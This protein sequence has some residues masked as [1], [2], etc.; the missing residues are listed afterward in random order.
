MSKKAVGIILIVL[1]CLCIIGS[2]TFL[3]TGGILG[4][5][6]GA[7]GAGGELNVENGAT[8]ETVDGVVYDVYDGGTT[9]LYN[10]DGY[11]YIGSLSVENSTYPMGTT[12]EVQYDSSDPSSFAVP[13][14]FD[15][16]G[17]V[18]TVVGIAGVVGGI[19]GLIIGVVVLIIGIKLVKKAK[20]ETADT[21]V[22]PVMNA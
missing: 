11:D 14:L 22:P 16:F 12:V 6:F 9:I 7:I 21:T 13:E 3:G 10:V 5:V 15:A 19:L 2:V 20:K 17:S 4:I 18:G 1:A 8:V